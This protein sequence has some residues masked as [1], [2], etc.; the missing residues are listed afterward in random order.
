[1]KR[2]LTCRC[3]R[4]RRWVERF[5]D[6][7]PLSLCLF[8]PACIIATNGC[9]FRKGQPYRH[10]NGRVLFA[11]GSP[12]EPVKLDGR[13]FVPRQ[14]NNSYIFPGVGLGAIASGTRRITDEMFMRLP[15]RAL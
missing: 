13:I 11:C 8:W 15:S 14:G 9:D 12:Y 10:T 3:A 5:N 4:M 2:A 1:M 6:T 7:E